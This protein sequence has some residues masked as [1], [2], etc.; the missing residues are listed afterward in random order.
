MNLSTEHTII[1]ILDKLQ[2]TLGESNASINNFKY[3]LETEI[4]KFNLTHLKLM[5]VNFILL[6][7]VSFSVA[8]M[9]IVNYTSIQELNQ[10]VAANYETITTKDNEIAALN[11]RLVEMQNEIMELKS[12]IEQKE[13]PIDD[14]PIEEDPV[15]TYN[16]TDISYKSGYTAEQF[17]EIIKTAFA[18][19]NKTETLFSTLGE[20]LY[21][22]EQEYDVNGLYL[23]GI[24]SLESGWGTSSY[25]KNKN[26]IYGLV[27]M[28]FDSLTDCTVY[29]GKLIRNSYLNAG[30]TSLYS[31]QRKYCPNGGSTWVNNVT[32]CAN[33]YIDAATQLYSQ[34]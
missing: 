16:N 12:Q 4:N 11:E 33:K 24:A 30:Y 14:Q 21:Q 1:D 13:E 15:V 6:I 27:G 29:M 25:A 2:Y 26:N 3:N 8:T 5:I 23:L 31:I 32:W 22:A 28:D 19:M 9:M 7:L 17:T 34:Q 20:G 18:G 10:T